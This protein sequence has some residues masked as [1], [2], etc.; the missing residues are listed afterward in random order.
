MAYQIHRKNKIYE[1]LELFN[2]RGE[3]AETIVVELS[4]DGMAGRLGRAYENLTKA[5]EKLKSNPADAEAFGNAVLDVFRV[6]FG[7][8]DTERILKFY[9]DSYTEM[10][11]DIAPFINDVVMPRVKSA[12]AARKAQLKRHW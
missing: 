5:Q 1:T 7:D 6:V 3:L 12:S 2:A 10:L 9:E 4:L 11:A 8:A